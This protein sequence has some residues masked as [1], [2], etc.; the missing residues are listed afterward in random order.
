MSKEHKLPKWFWVIG[1]IMIIIVSVSYK[2][3]GIETAQSNKIL[4]SG[5]VS[6]DIQKAQAKDLIPGTDY[7]CEEVIPNSPEANS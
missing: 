6:P 1:I 5:I 2:S 4:S 3:N 7:S